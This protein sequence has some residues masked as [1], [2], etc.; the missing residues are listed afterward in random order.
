MTSC[1]CGM[2]LVDGDIEYLRGEHEHKQIHS[3]NK[4]Q[5]FCLGCQHLRADLD[6]ANRLA[7]EWQRAA[8]TAAAF[9]E[10]ERSRALA[11]EAERDA[12][13]AEVLRSNDLARSA[14]FNSAGD[15]LAQ[16][17]IRLSTAEAEVERLKNVLDK[18][19]A[20][21]KE[22]TTNVGQL[23]AKLD[24]YLHTAEADIERLKGVIEFESKA[25]WELQNK[26]QAVSKCQ[27][28]GEVLTT[29]LGVHW[30]K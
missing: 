18:R 30:C 11:A 7:A 1:K 29:K 20:S 24:T 9:R 25:R 5:P 26:N 27:N 13:T 4:C 14:G 21:I 17:A 12:I 3:R 16:V 2:M 6:A 10:G 19:E 15:M 8:Q 23:R 28:C 22:L